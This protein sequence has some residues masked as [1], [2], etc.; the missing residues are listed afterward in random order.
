[1]RRISVALAG[2]P[3]TGKS[4]IFNRLTGS[5]ACEGN[6]P[7][8]T[9]ELACGSRTCGDR[10]LEFMDLPGQYSLSPAS[11]DES[12]AV[13]YLLETPPDLILDVVDAA[14]LERNL[15]LTVQLAALGLPM[16]IALNMCDEAA[17]AGRMPD[18]AVLS[19]RLGVK[20]VRTIGRTGIGLE[21]LVQALVEASQDGAPPRMQALG[22]DVDAEI[23]RIAAMLP[24]LEVDGRG[25]AA[26][27]LEGSEEAAAAVG[28]A[29]AGASARILE[30]AGTASRKL[31]RL[32]ADPVQIVLAG[33]RRGVAS[34]LVM[35]S[36]GPSRR[37]ST[38]PDVTRRVDAVLLNRFLGVPAFA[39]IMYA[40]FWLTFRAS[41]P[42]ERLI[43]DAFGA[44]AG[45]ASTLI[46]D[47]A[48]RSLV[49]DGVIGGV[50]GV[51]LFVPAIAILFLLISLME[52]TGYMARAAFLTDG[53][54]HKV[55]LHGR[56][57]IPMILGFGCTVPAVMATRTLEDRR[58]RLA[59]I[60]VLPLLSCGARL[61]GYLLVIGAFFPRHKALM[62]AF[63]YSVGIAL[64]LAAARILRKTVLRGEDSPFVMELPPYRL[65]T[66]AALARHVWRRVRHY[67]AK[68]GTVILAFSIVLW[69]LGY[70]PRQAAGADATAAVGGSF[71]ERLGHAVEPIVRPLGFDWRIATAMIGAAG[72]KEIFVSQMG[73]LTSL[74]GGQGRDLTSRMAALYDPGT[75]LAIMLFLLIS[76]PC[77]ATV[78]MVRRET[79][80]WGLA[81]AQYAGLTALAWVIAFLGKWAFGISRFF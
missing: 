63:I 55:G 22:E 16:V 2:N 67:L 68:A 58:D 78:A 33:L 17:A 64:A 60:L 28:R 23:S 45:L 62:L 65:P 43:A 77:L 38:G 57:F 81:A 9:V 80:S 74:E 52:D 39:L 36:V 75:G 18:P 15:Q 51:V 25:I 8:V 5:S 49:A 11:S 79:G 42:L 54:M 31:E 3:N 30:A 69:F 37:R 34:G 76:A 7:G 12:V 29:A 44:L 46:P 21:E 73:I 6:Y 10:R 35:E 71:A 41:A 61:P 20:V 32:Y 27:L 24:P 40:A 66:L 53:L 48:I 1:M 70:F 13:R 72:A 56:S 4:T 50:G 47:G 14:N 59:T 19:A 26:M